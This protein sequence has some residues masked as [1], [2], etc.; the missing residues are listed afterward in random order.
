MTRLNA[1]LLSRYDEIRRLKRALQ[2]QLKRHGSRLLKLQ[3]SRRK[4]QRRIGRALQKQELV[5]A[6]ITRL[7]L[8]E[9]EE[10]EFERRCRRATTDVLPIEILGEIFCLV[11]DEP[12]SKFDSLDTQNSAPWVIA[13]VGHRWRSIALSFSK[14]WCRVLIND[15]PLS[16]GRASALQH[17]LMWSGAYPLY[18]SLDDCCLF[19]HLYPHA[20]HLSSLECHSLLHPEELQQIAAMDLPM[21]KV[22]YINSHIPPDEA[23]ISVDDTDPSLEVPPRDPLFRHAPQLVEFH[24]FGLAFSLFPPPWSQIHTF[25]GD[26]FSYD[27]FRLLC[28]SAINLED[29]HISFRPKSST[30]LPEEARLFFPSLR[31]LALYT[32]K[33]CLTQIHSPNLQTFCLSM[34]LMPYIR[35]DLMVGLEAFISTHKLDTFFLNFVAPWPTL[36]PV[37]QNCGSRLR[38]LSLNVTGLVAWSLYR[39]LTHGGDMACYVPNLEVL[40]LRD[41]AYTGYIW[42]SRTM[43][44]ARAFVDNELVTMVESR[45][46]DSRSGDVARL[47]KL[48]LC[49]PY[50]PFSECSENMVLRKLKGLEETYGFVFAV[51]WGYSWLPYEVLT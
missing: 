37:L 10:E 32:D 17:V 29:A 27:D 47:Q 21:L 11:A 36:H 51:H 6:K 26:I 41:E 2:S 19:P 7:S 35:V 8:G 38:V 14:L 42:P 25:K 15:T 12:N 33:P 46:G 34:L 16:P 1:S 28:Q 30:L 3:R 43:Q 31:H 5:V 23:L 22:L 49:A 4:I 50:S 18:V 44:H 48:V 24:L 39:A 20:S 9:L 13:H 40:Y 45:L